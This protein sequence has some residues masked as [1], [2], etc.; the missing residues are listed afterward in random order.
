[1]LRRPL[2][3]TLAMAGGLSTGGGS[4]VAN[5]AHL[6]PA[7]K[8]EAEAVQAEFDN[9]DWNPNLAAVVWDDTVSITDG[10]ELFRWL[11]NNASIGGV[12]LN[13]ARNQRVQ[14]ASGGDFSFGASGQTGGGT[15]GII[16]IR[17]RDYMASGKVLLI[18][19]A[20]TSPN[21]TQQLRIS[22]CRGVYLRGLSWVGGLD[23]WGLDWQGYAPLSL[24]GLTIANGGTGYVTGEALTF[25]GTYDQ[26]PVGTIITTAGIITGVNIT[27][28]GKVVR[29]PNGGASL[30]TS[31]GVATAGGTGAV[32]TVPTQQTNPRDTTQIFVQRTGTSFP[33]LP[34]IVIEG[35]KI[36][37]G[38]IENSPAKFNCGISAT[39]C[40]QITVKDVAF[41]GFQT[42]IN[43]TTV[44][45]FKRHGCDF[46]LGIA[47]RTI[48][49]NTAADMAVTGGTT[50]STAW[51]DKLSYVW[52]RRNTARNSVDACAL[53]NSQGEEL[54]LDQE[55]TDFIQHGTQGDTGGYRRLVEFDAAYMERETYVD[56]TGAFRNN[57][58]PTTRYTGQ[59]QGTYED[60]SPST[61]NISGVVHSNILCV[62]SPNGLTGYHGTSYLARNTVV[63]VGRMAPSATTVPD[64]FNF[65]Q[66]FLTNIVLRKKDAGAS[67]TINVRDNIC[68]A[69][70]NQAAPSDVILNA[71]GNIVADPRLT[72]VAPNRYADVF[73]GTFT[74][75]NGLTGYSF[76]DDGVS[77]Q[78]A[79]RAALFAQ[80]EPSGNPDKGAPN[81]ALWP[82]T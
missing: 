79:F 42:G 31:V 72:A 1:M 62:N 54:R 18:E 38:H 16:E 10:G 77:S 73:K 43:I 29:N 58:T 32:L 63:R 11:R 55:H 19:P 52:S 46:Q 69:I 4:N 70:T 2:I 48:V 30:I 8:A 37:K 36:G 50:F 65:S 28:G 71:S 15:P 40:E 51:P 13:P 33:L 60:D 20:T 6:T 74:T 61:L 57:A 59:T 41:K 66:D 64:G 82:T 25:T 27:F 78:A 9:N 53:T 23:D 44:R 45:R 3:R 24:H 12:T 68:T 34:V 56:R 67:A 75:V 76:T 17:G 49:L 47:D 22:G 7:E 81:P 5:R 14:L 26:A 21:I 80:F 35:G 39:N